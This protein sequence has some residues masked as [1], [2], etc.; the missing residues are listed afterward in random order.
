MT[1]NNAEEIAGVN[2]EL[3]PAQLTAR[4]SKSMGDFRR[5]MSGNESEIVSMMIFTISF[6][7]GGV[8]NLSCSLPL[9]LESTNFVIIQFPDVVVIWKTNRWFSPWN[10]WEWIEIVS[11]MI[12]KISFSL[13]GVWNLSRSLPLQLESTNFVIVQFSDAI[14]IWKINEWSKM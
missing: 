11:M 5:G 6:S 2:C 13:G 1:T 12:F 10:V 7:L 14:V 4:S 9:Q 8:W 3:E